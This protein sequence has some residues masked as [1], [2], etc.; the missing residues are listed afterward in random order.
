ML[1]RKLMNRFTEI[2]LADRD[3]KEKM[4]SGPVLEQNRFNELWES[5]PTEPECALRDQDA[6]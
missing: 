5:A 4:R 1:M 3:A 2:D 6:T